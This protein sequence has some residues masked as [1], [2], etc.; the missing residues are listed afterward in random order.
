MSVPALLARWLW[1]AACVVSFAAGLYL[2]RANETVDRWAAAAERLIRPSAG[3]FNE[4]N[5]LV[6]FGKRQ[7]ACPPQSART[8]VAVLIGQSN[9]ANTG[10]H[11]FRGKP[12]VF[13]FFDG[14][15]FEAVDPLLGT[16][17]KQ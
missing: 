6:R 7:V 14:K 15:C 9:A 13:N 16:A 4:H 8:L 5:Q 3:P 11:R 1:P 12:N 2:G 17:D 10:G